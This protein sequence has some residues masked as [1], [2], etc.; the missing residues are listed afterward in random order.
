MIGQCAP[1]ICQRQLL[2]RFW[3]AF[4]LRL[5]SGE[6]EAEAGGAP[7]V[8]QPKAQPPPSSRGRKPAGRE[9]TGETFTHLV[10]PLC[11]SALY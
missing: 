4:G 7:R 5:A 1:D 8:S 2:L 6:I 10:P 9:A 3:H 11:A